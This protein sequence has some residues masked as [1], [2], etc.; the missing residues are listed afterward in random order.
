MQRISFAKSLDSN[1][2]I[3][4]SNLH[5]KAHIFWIKTVD[6]ITQNI[7]SR[8]APNIGEINKKRSWAPGEISSSRKKLFLFYILSCVF[9]SSNKFQDNKSDLE[10][11]ITAKTCDLWNYSK[12]KISS[13]NWSWVSSSWMIHFCKPLVLRSRRTFSKNS[14]TLFWFED[15]VTCSLWYMIAYSL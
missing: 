15:N 3:V 4:H 7:H 9:A 14:F 5:L 13:L 10:K 8:H 2:Q 12:L 11:M 1:H 6:W